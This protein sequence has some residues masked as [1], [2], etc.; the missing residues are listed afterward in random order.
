MIELCKKDDCTGCMACAN[1]CPKSAITMLPDEEGFLFPQ[2]NYDVCISCKLCQ[3]KCPVLNPVKLNQ[4]GKAFAAMSKH[5]ETRTTSSSGGMFYSIAKWIIEN[6]G[7][8]FGAIFD[9]NMDLMHTETDNLSG[10]K[11]MQG[12]KYLQSN[13]NN[14]LKKALNHLQDNRLVL[15]TGTPCQIAA[16]KKLVPHKLQDKLYT[17]DIVCHGVPSNKLFQSYLNKLQKFYPKKVLSSFRFRD[18]EGWSCQ[19]NINY[20]GKKTALFGKQAIYSELFM[21]GYIHRECC[22]NCLYAQLK[23]AGDLTIADYWGIGTIEP[24]SHDTSE[25][26]SLIICNNQKGCN[27]LHAIKNEL[28]IEKRSFHESLTANKQLSTPSHRP[29]KR[30]TIY[31]YFFTHSLNEIYYKYFPIRAFRRFISRTF[32]LFHLKK[33]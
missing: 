29:Q 23:R 21:G 19:S 20:N 8:V 32:K 25:G 15:F 22:Y 11:K 1:I 30:D 6:N 13:I 9:D 14:T 5:Q 2:I 4:E 33:Q 3:Q 16:I 18:T 17:V 31:Q 7:I 27:I 24:Y 10:L 28:I 26:V 12:S